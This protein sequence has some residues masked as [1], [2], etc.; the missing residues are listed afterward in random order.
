MSTSVTLVPDGAANLV[1]TPLAPGGTEQN[2]RPRRPGRRDPA[3]EPHFAFDGSPRRSSAS[4]EPTPRPFAVR[5]LGRVVRTDWTL[6]RP[7]TSLRYRR[8]RLWT[9]TFLQER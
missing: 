9:M 1:A 5:R 8:G 4:V 2:R 3:L 7:R 6:P